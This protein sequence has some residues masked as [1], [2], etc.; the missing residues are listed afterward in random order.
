MAQGDPEQASRPGPRTQLA[1]LRPVCGVDEW[2]AGPELSTGF[3]GAA[4][5]FALLLLSDVCVFDRRPPF[6][7]VNLLTVQPVP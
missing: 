2:G 4:E 3:L 7:K 6:I 5:G 1:P